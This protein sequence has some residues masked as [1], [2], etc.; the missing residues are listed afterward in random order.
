MREKVQPLTYH[1]KT[2][3]S[4]YNKQITKSERNRSLSL[5]CI[6]LCVYAKLS[7]VTIIT[8]VE[9]SEILFSC[10]DDSGCVYAGRQCST[11]EVELQQKTLGAEDSILT[12]HTFWEILLQILY[13]VQ[14]TEWSLVVRCT[15]LIHGTVLL[16]WVYLRFS[17]GQKRVFQLPP[18]TVLQ[19]TLQMAM[20]HTEWIPIKLD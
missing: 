19:F 17:P 2:H 8:S 6:G 15:R 7:R 11:V 3:T 4:C 9:T 14:L 5:S 1:S 10:S 18:L 12:W 20:G 16:L 13:S